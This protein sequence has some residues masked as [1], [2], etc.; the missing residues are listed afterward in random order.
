[1]TTDRPM[2]RRRLEDDLRDNQGDNV[3]DRSAKESENEV[4][5]APGPSDPV[6]DPTVSAPNS[7]EDG[8][9]RSKLALFLYRASQ[10]NNT[11]PERTVRKQVH[12]TTSY[13]F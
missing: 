8:P 6:F 7:H 9:N 3:G 11:N 12:V 1:M 13:R 4:S 2:K 5:E 10:P